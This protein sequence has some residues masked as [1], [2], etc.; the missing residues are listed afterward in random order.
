MTIPNVTRN[1]P[2]AEQRLLAAAVLVVKSYGEAV[3]DLQSGGALA[4]EVM[5]QAVWNYHAALT[6]AHP[7][8]KGT[9]FSEWLDKNR[10]HI[11]P[12]RAEHP[13]AEAILHSLE[14]IAQIYAMHQAAKTDA[15]GTRPKTV[16]PDPLDLGAIMTRIQ[17]LDPELARKILDFFEKHGLHDRKPPEGAAEPPPNAATKGIHVGDLSNRL[18]AVRDFLSG[19]YPEIW[20]EILFEAAL[21]D[22]RN[23]GDL[24]YRIL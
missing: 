14:G 5:V 21:D 19:K 18:S 1:L 4:D 20:K 22:E 11:P 2:E 24:L 7:E 8:V 12:A 6:E 9:S 23:D 17:Q 16:S 15:P 13:I 10:L 3:R